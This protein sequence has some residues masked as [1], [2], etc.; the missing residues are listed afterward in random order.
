[1][2][3]K[4]KK[5]N[6]WLIYLLLL[7]LCIVLSVVIY[8]A[9]KNNN[10]EENNVEED[11]DDDVVESSIKP[12]DSAKYMKVTIGDTEYELVLE[13]NLSAMD[14][15]SISPLEIDMEDLNNNE[16]YY[17]LS[18][19]LSDSDGYNGEIKKGDVLL[20][21]SNCIVIFYEDFDT[22]N[23]Y[24][25]LGHINGLESLSDGTVKVIFYE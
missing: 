19:S 1:M 2:A 13:N 17:Y 15:L 6:K 10:N 21:Q 25:K 7:V 8:F 5:E 14:L 18:Y 11:I 4:N 9:V 16:K 24:I 12:F 22:D 23:N 3:K 20:Y